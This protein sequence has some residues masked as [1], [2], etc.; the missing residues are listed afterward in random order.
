[1]KIA[2][3]FNILISIA[4]ILAPL[5]AHP[6]GTVVLTNLGES[7][8]TA[9]AV[10]SSSLAAQWFHTGDNFGP[11]GGGYRLDS[12]QLLM[13]TPA[14]NPNAFSVSIHGASRNEGPGGKVGNLTGLDPTSNG[15]FT[16][17]AP[18]ITLSPLTV[19]WIVVTSGTPLAQGSY[20]W[21]IANSSSYNSNGAW[22]MGSFYDFSV[23]GQT[24]SRNG[25]RPLQFAVNATA[26]PE[27]SSLTLF[28]FAGLLLGANLLRRRL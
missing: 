20:S 16:Y 19:Y 25:N 15:V 11:G 23:D 13:S 14:G 5:D 21:N 12:V 8:S 27:P 6:Q 22:L 24:W 1:M 7:S 28:G 18:N 10:S 4:G 26:V 9:I 3:N 17:S 2:G